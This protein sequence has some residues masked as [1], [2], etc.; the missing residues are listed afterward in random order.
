MVGIMK[1]TKNNLYKI[2]NL[3]SVRESLKKQRSVKKKI[4]DEIKETELLKRY[5]ELEYMLKECI[6]MENDLKKMLKDLKK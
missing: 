3:K 6:D 4:I 1:Y 5:N 2:Y